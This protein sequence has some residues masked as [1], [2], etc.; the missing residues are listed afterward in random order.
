MDLERRPTFRRW[1]DS[2]ELG[3]AAGRLLSEVHRT[4][5]TVAAGAAHDPQPTYKRQPIRSSTRC[6]RISSHCI[7]PF[8]RDEYLSHF[9]YLLANGYHVSLFLIF[10]NI[11]SRPGNLGPYQSR[12]PACRVR[13][14]QTGFFW[15][16]QTMH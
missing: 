2:A 11:S 4:C 12:C 7:G 9:N 14:G 6:R 3:S 10:C 1:P 13:V 16:L 5:P 8:V 15:T